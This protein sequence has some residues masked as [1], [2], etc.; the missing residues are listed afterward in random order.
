MSPYAFGVPVVLGWA[1]LPAS[2]SRGE[3]Q[4]FPLADRL[5]LGL[6]PRRVGLVFLRAGRTLFPDLK[7]GLHRIAAEFL[8]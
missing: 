6:G 2:S 5:D 3:T 1:S 7:P 4:V 8:R